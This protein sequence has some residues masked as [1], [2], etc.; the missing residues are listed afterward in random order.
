MNTIELA[1]KA[2]ICGG[3]EYM[4]LSEASNLEAFRALCVAERDK[5][6]MGLG[7]EPFG[8]LYNEAKR[9]KH[10]T[11]GIF[12]RFKPQGKDFYEITA[13]LYT[14]EELA[15]ARLQATEQA[16]ARAN[17]SWALM[18][19]KMV[20]AALVQERERLN[21]DWSLLEATQQSLREHQQRIAELEANLKR[22]TAALKAQQLETTCE[23]KNCMNATEAIES[24]KEKT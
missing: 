2:G 12:S 9:D 4:I 5:E 10:W 13:T 23:C 7:V 21:P 3:N 24:T 8:W 22:A 1:K 15:A 14:S 20:A 17:K 19:E 18:C 16:N 6:L 11:F